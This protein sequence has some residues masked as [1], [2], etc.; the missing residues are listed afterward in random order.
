MKQLTKEEEI[1][2]YKNQK[3]VKY[4]KMNI[5]WIK[6]VPRISAYIYYKD[7]EW[8][9]FEYSHKG[10]GIDLYSLLVGKVFNEF[11]RYKLFDKKSLNMREIPYGVYP[12]DEIPKYE[13]GTGISSLVDVSKWMG[14]ELKSIAWGETFEVFEYVDGEEL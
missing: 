2:K 5:E 12:D 13:Q 11:L 10:T 9:R 8:V 7:G 4:I 14:G 6:K 1:E 3:H